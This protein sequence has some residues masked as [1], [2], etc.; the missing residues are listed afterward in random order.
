MGISLSGDEPSSGH[1]APKCSCRNASDLEAVTTGAARVAATFAVVAAACLVR[2]V[3][4]ARQL[5]TS[6]ES[7]LLAATSSTSLAAGWW[8]LRSMSECSP[9]TIFDSLQDLA[10]FL[11]RG[12]GKLFEIPGDLWGRVNQ[13]LGILLVRVN[14]LLGIIVACTAILGVAVAVAAVL[15]VAFGLQ[16]P[17]LREFRCWA[18]AVRWPWSAAPSN[19]DEENPPVVVPP[20]SPVKPPPSAEASPQD[21]PPPGYYKSRYTT[22]PLLNAALDEWCSSSR[23][24]RPNTKRMSRSDTEEACWKAGLR[25]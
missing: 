18:A 25:M 12:L 24:E 6:T 4:G 10:D 2:K 15:F 9:R 3:A 11:V 20:A 16:L 14:Q 7:F 1:T 5:L 23:V 19:K 17:Q 8:A 22:I 21:T 13:L